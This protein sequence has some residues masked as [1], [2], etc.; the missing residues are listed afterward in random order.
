MQIN[1]HFL[2]NTLQ[3]INWRGKLLKDEPI[4]LMT[5][6]LGKLLRITL[7]RKNKDSTLAQEL[8]LV[9]Y[10]MNIQGI[11][12]EDTLQYKVNIP[13]ELLDTYTAQVYPAA[14]D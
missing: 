10:Y 13:P 7:S 12:F 6:S 14:S 4:S 9:R 11:R 1:P 8:E 3:T 5:E 2:Y